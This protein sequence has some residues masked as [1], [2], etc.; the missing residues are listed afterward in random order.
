MIKGKCGR[1]M[2]QY[3]SI[4]SAAVPAF[5]SRCLCD[6][7]HLSACQTNDFAPGSVSLSDMQTYPTCSECCLTA[8]DL[9]QSV[10]AHLIS[11]LTCF[12]CASKVYDIIFRFCIFYVANI[13]YR[14][15][16]QGKLKS[17]ILV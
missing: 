16:C 5:T 9:S 8:F 15:Y 17:E 3:L 12:V 11:S 2:I 14:K 6:S 10:K 4:S 7:A 13:F 1:E